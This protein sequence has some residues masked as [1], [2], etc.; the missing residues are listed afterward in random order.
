MITHAIVADGLIGLAS[1]IST[2]PA[3]GGCV[4]CFAGPPAYV[5][6]QGI[7]MISTSR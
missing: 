1:G 2:V 4:G 5:F 3:G 6:P 7:D